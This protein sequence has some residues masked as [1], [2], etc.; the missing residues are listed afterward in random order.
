[1]KLREGSIIEVRGFVM[2]QNLNEGKYKVNSVKKIYGCMAYSFVKP[3]GKRVIVNHVADNVDC[4]VKS[5][6]DEDLN[7]IVV[8][9][10]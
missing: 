5:S 2:L 3:F 1:M 6:S 8:L 7:K 10:Y 9:K 4:W